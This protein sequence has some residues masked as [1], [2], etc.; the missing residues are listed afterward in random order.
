MILR[1][2]AVV[3]WKTGLPMVRPINGPSTVHHLHDVNFAFVW[4]TAVVVGHKPVSGPDALP[5]FSTSRQLCRDA[6]TKRARSSCPCCFIPRRDRASGVVCS[7]HSLALGPQDERSVV[8]VHV[9]SSAG[10][11]PARTKQ[12][13]IVAQAISAEVRFAGRVR[14]GGLGSLLA[15]GDRPD[16]VVQRAA[17]EFVG[18]FACPRGVGVTERTSMWGRIGRPSPKNSGGN[19]SRST[20]VEGSRHLQR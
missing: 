2:R 19:H 12:D 5:A 11:A 14:E 15:N 6:H 9:L 18:E 10:R 3:L 20:E 17:V 4:V 13:A 1:E 7:L 16:F 8:Q